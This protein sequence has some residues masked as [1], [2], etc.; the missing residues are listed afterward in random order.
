MQ[1]GMKC[2]CGKSY[3]AKSADLKRGWGL[4]CGKR[5]AAVRRK[6]K[7]PAATQLIF[8]IKKVNK[9]PSSDRVDKRIILNISNDLYS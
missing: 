4:S 3:E 5:C 1:I 8:N 2:H 6:Y 9:T 7:K